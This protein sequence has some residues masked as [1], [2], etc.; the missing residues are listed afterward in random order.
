MLA[1]LTA[2]R[3]SVMNAEVSGATST[4]AAKRVSTRDLLL[5]AAFD[6]FAEIGFAGTTISEIERRV[7]L[8]AGS[9][10]FYRH[11]SSKE[12]LLPAAVERELNKAIADVRS[13][14]PDTLPAR[15]PREVW[16]RRILMWLRRTE[17]LNRLLLLEGDR[18]PA[19]REAITSAVQGMSDEL[20][21][22]DDP[23][24][25]ISVAALN[26]YLLFSRAIG[27]P[28]YGVDE[29]EFIAALATLA[30]RRPSKPLQP[31]STRRVQR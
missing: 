18:V 1:S 4:Y 9:G 21:W 15:Q 7:G 12:E 8:A 2:S 26:G 14:Y 11:F 25:I 20:S 17:R 5:D 19:I 6:L 23:A 29:D 30:P 27:A 13:A 10:S 22:D 28:Y 24:G 3:G 16:L 31:T